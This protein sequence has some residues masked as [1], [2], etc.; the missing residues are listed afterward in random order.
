MTLAAR[1]RQ[2]HYDVVTPIGVGWGRYAAQVIA[3][4]RAIGARA[5]TSSGHGCPRDFDRDLG[6][7]EL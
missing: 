6:D 2:V 7:D 1:T 4:S 3:T 5:E